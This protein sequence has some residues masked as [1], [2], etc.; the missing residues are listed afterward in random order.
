MNFGIQKFLGDENYS[1]LSLVSKLLIL[2][3][4]ILKQC[5][6]QHIYSIFE[7]SYSKK[8]F[9]SRQHLHWA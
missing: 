1:Q 4:N 6:A 7:N 5:I 2:D 3:V 9:D 8:F